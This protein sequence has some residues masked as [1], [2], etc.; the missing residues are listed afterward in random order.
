MAAVLRFHGGHMKER[1]TKRLTWGGLK[2]ILFHER[3]G[4]NFDHDHIR[5]VY[6]DGHRDFLNIKHDIYGTPYFII[7]KDR[8]RY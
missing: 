2:R 7:V 1:Q 8:R 6:P 3:T 4:A 5:L